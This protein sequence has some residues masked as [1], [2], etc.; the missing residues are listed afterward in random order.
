MLQA[1]TSR[2][3]ARLIAIYL[4]LCAPALV[5]PNQYLESPLWPV[6][7]IPYL[8]IYLFHQVGIPGL[9][10]NRGM[11]GWGWCPPSVFGWLFLAVFWLLV[12]W[13]VARLIDRV[14]PASD[15]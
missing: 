1:R 4:L 9:L 6:L 5:W 14:F 7:A 15:S 12:F 8:S 13:L 2:I 3:F 10:Q 11:C